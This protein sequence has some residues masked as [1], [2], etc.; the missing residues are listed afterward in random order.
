MKSERGFKYYTFSGPNVVA[1]GQT[2]MLDLLHL[3]SKPT[4]PSCPIATAPRGDRS[5]DALWELHLEFRNCYHSPAS[6]R[7]LLLHIYLLILLYGNRTN[8]VRSFCVMYILTFYLIEKPTI[9]AINIIL[10]S[11]VLTTEILK[12]QEEEENSSILKE[13]IFASFT[14]HWTTSKLKASFWLMNLT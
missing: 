1:S 5:G 9:W 14:S 4:V 13:L 10:C 11:V 12:G 8:E 2:C 3:S 7:F 6:K